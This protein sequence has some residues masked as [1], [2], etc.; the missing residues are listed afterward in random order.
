METL[1]F[2]KI[3]SQHPGYSVMEVDGLMPNIEL[4]IQGKQDVATTLKKAQEQGDK[5]LDQNAAGK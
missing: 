2:A 5:L 3:R 4:F 1:E